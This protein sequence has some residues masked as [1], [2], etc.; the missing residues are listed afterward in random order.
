M[1]VSGWGALC[2]GCI[3]PDA[4]HVV[5]VPG[6]SNAI[7]NEKYD[8]IITDQMLCAGEIVNGGVDSCQGDSGGNLLNT[9]GQFHWH[10][11]IS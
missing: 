3:S 6:V 8:G 2:S 7:C 11:R 4:L 9:F 5:N 10:S 1:T